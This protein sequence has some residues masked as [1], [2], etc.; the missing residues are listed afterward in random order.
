MMCR[1]Y[2]DTYW[3]EKETDH[4]NEC[5]MVSKN[6]LFRFHVSLTYEIIQT[7]LSVPI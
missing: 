5:L 6:H 2:L 7:A 4:C 1:N 3:E